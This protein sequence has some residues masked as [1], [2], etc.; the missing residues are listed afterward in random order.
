MAATL[1]MVWNTKA[2]WP[3]GVGFPSNQA[4]TDFGR[5]KHAKSGETSKGNNPTQQFAAFQVISYT[6]P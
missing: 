6:G 5:R 2:Q 3:D 1:Y 4:A